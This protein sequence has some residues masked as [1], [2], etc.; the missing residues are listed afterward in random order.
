[1]RAEI[2][3]VLGAVPDNPDNRDIP[4]LVKD[5]RIPDRFNL[6]AYAGK[7]Y[8]Q[9]KIGSCTG[10]TLAKCEEVMKRRIAPN[11]SEKVQ[12]VSPLFTYALAREKA[13]WPDYDNGAFLRDVLK[14]SAKIGTLP[15]DLYTGKNNWAQ[16]PT[17]QERSFAEHGRIKG[18]ERISVRGLDPVQDMRI[19]LAEENLPILISLQLFDGFHGSNTRRSGIVEMP[20]DHSR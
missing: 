11:Q 9:G 3:Y 13:K 17:Q 20:G 4:K 14:V 16:L 10:Q 12:L 5:V 6:F 19:V 7:P 1:M 18:Y 8:R 15:E 2:K